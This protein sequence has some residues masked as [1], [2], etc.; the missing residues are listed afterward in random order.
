MGI[1]FATSTD[2]SFVAGWRIGV[3]AAHFF[4]LR[5]ASVTVEGDGASL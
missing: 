3:F 4:P 5:M 2:G 1:D